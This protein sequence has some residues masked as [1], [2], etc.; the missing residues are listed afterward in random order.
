MWDQVYRPLGDS[1]PLSALCA[2]LPIFV[3]LISLGVFRVAAWKSGLLGLATSIVVAIAVYG[4]PV[5]LVLGATVYGVD[6]LL[7][8]RVVPTDR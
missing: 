1:L 6:C 2:A 3:L 4:M 8:T 5:H 7:G